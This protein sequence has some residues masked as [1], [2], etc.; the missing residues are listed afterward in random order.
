MTRR[1]KKRSKQS[2]GHINKDWHSTPSPHK[3]RNE[4]NHWRLHTTSITQSSR[5][6]LFSSQPATR[7]SESEPRHQD[8]RRQTERPTTR[9]GRRTARW[10]GSAAWSRG[11][12]W[13]VG[14]WTMGVKQGSACWDRLVDISDCGMGCRVSS[15]DSLTTGVGG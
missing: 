5:A 6:T 12:G 8:L 3:R 11:W 14:E 13:Y 9:E 10:L 1:E 7:A 2:W 4:H 15:S